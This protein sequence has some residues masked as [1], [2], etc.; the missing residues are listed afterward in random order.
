MITVFLVTAAVIILGIDG[1]IQ[2]EVIGTVLGALSGY[3]LGRS[4]NSPFTRR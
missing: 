2:A 3:L 1:R 4:V